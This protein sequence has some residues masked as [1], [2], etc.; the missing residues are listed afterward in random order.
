MPAKP[1]RHGA[2]RSNAAAAQPR[3]SC[4]LRSFRGAPAPPLGVLPRQPEESQRSGPGPRHAL[5]VSIEMGRGQ[6]WHRWVGDGEIISL[7]R[8]GASAPAADVIRGL[9]YSVEAVVAK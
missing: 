3:W 9:G 6:G 7:N 8:F 5:R 1:C 4:R 2:W